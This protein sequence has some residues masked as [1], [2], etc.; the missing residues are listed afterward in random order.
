[1]PPSPPSLS[2]QTTAALINVLVSTPLWCTARCGV[3]W[4]SPN[5][6]DMI[7]TRVRTT[8]IVITE[9]KEP[10][11]TYQ[12]PPLSPRHWRV[13]FIA[14]PHRRPSPVDLSLCCGVAVV[15]TGGGRRGATE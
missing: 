1:M 7:M 4:C 11:Y 3:V 6:D 10:P 14:T 8:G 12:V 9:V 5:E 13:L 15:L 2:L